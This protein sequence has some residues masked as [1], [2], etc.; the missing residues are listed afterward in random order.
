MQQLYY[1]T[2]QVQEEQHYSNLNDGS[3]CCREDCQDPGESRRSYPD[4]YGV[5][6]GR[7]T[8]AK[9]HAAIMS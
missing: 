8:V 1:P 3:Y 9:P 7:D 5:I 4:G 2:V 6:L